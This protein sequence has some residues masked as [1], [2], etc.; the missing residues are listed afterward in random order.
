M[1][2]IYTYVY[3]LFIYLFFRKL[4][5]NCF[6]FVYFLL[7]YLFFLYINNKNKVQYIV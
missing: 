1:Y 3:S 7:I 4:L 2:Y 6:I 5:T